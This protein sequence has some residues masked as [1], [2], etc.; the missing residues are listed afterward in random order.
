VLNA[1]SIG[2]SGARIVFHHILPNL[3]SVVL[4]QTS[5]LLSAAILVEASLSFLGLG[6]QPPSPSLGTMLADGRN[7]LMLSP[8]SAVFSG[9]A[10]LILAFALN[11]LGDALRDTLDPR[12]RGE[13]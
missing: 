11:L 4:V 13:R 5:L 9:L 10:I 6:A 1:R 12:L 7:F 3:A 8:W 2:A